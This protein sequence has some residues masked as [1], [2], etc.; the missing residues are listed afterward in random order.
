MNIR[1]ALFALVI[2]L[3]AVVTAPASAE[4]VSGTPV[5][6]DSRLIQYPYDED[7]TY[8]VLAKPKAVTHLKFAAN[9]TI[10]SVAA[11]DTANWEL[12][13]TKD[14]H[15][16][17]V[18]PKFEGDE[19]SL[20]VLTDQRVYQFVLR[21][22]GEGKKWYQR[23][24]WIY[25]GDLLLSLPEIDAPPS[26]ETVSH[27]DAGPMKLTVTPDQA[28]VGNVPGGKGLDKLRFG[29][30]ISG[31]APFKPVIVFDD[32]RFTYFKLPPNVQELPALFAIADG[33]EYS[34]VNFEV[35]GEYIVAQRLLPAAV[36]KL[37][38]AEVRVKQQLAQPKRSFFGFKVD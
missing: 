21:S 29:Y 30:E 2:G 38:L 18:K 20:T 16:M 19:T 25:G 11:G 17:F 9:E 14:R 36:L 33:T 28:S 22:T 31:D 12:T 34:L 37:G 13:P 23:V 15:N 4:L 7:N 32:G 1:F 27:G 3:Q 5:R 10:R 35:Q 8:L 24:S 6:G 26:P